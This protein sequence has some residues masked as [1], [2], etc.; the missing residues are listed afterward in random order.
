MYTHTKSNIYTQLFVAVTLYKETS[1]TQMIARP[2]V[3][4]NVPSPC[5]G[6]IYYLMFV[7]NNIFK[8]M[9]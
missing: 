1:K 5:Q 9:I 4:Y 7:H 2:Y 6:V 3:H 8:F